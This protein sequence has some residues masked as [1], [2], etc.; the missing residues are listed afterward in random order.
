M[1]ELS[2]KP[3]RK[4]GTD[5][6]HTTWASLGLHYQQSVW[7]KFLRAGVVQKPEPEGHHPAL[8]KPSG[9]TELQ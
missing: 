4:P 3:G 6:S 9:I 2:P 7:G 5:S 1:R 8:E